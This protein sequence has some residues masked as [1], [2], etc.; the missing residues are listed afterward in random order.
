MSSIFRCGAVIGR[1]IRPLRLCVLLAASI[2][3]SCYTLR[4]MDDKEKLSR[5]ESATKHLHAIAFQ[6]AQE[7]FYAYPQVATRVGVHRHKLA[8]DEVVR[9]D[10]ELPN[11]SEDL[12]AARVESLNAF[13]ARLDK[14]RR[15]RR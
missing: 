3:V 11:F 14:G 6:Y 12:V 2:A 10:R 13:L 8:N 1:G 7:T 9:L 5:A 15:P 4:V